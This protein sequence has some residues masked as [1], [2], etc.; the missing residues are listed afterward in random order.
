MTWNAMRYE[1]RHFL[2]SVGQ[3]YPVLKPVLGPAWDVLARW[4]EIRP[5][6]HR[7]RLPE[8]LFRAMFVLAIFMAGLA[9]LGSDSFAG[10]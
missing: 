4:E 3:T 6:R 10:L 9:A 5:V 2:V 8:V 1:L 7:V